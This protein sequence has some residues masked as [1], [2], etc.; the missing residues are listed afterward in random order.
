MRLRS[1]LLLLTLFGCTGG[2]SPG[3]P[4][5]TSVSKLIGASGGMVS[6]PAGASI[7]LPAGAVSGDTMISITATSSTPPSMYGQAVGVNYQF[8]PAGTLFL[9][10]V[11][12][13]LPFGK[14]PA[15]VDP[16]RDLQILTAPDGSN[17]YTSLGPANLLDSGHAG[18]TTL[19]FS[20]CV[21]ATVPGTGTT[22]GSSGGTSSTGGTNSTGGTTGNPG[23]GGVPAG[24]CQVAC[25]GSGGTATADAGGGSPTGGGTGSGG[26][27]TG[28]GGG[29]PTCGCQDACNGSS[30]QLVCDGTNCTCYQNGSATTMFAQGSICSANPYAD[31]ISNCGFPPSMGSTSVDGGSPDGGPQDGGTTTCMP[32]CGGGNGSCGCSETCNSITYGL[33]CTGTA[34]TCAES[35]S[36]STTMF[37]APGTP[38]DV[39]DFHGMC[40]AP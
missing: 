35:N 30:Y 25:F 31:W 22:G 36:M 12:M 11:T 27:T 28:S 20:M 16:T 33:S 26:S 23:D 38:C 34:C 9:K 2:T 17:V 39:T 7:V 32:S 15:G 4:V 1:T 40:G 3:D 6:T 24:Q 13:N 18:A 10:P 29:T 21:V 5:G 14:L 8:G 19:H 37:T